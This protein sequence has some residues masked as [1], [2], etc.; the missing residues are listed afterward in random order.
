MSG[1]YNWSVVFTISG[2]D[3]DG[4]FSVSH[5]SLSAATQEAQRGSRKQICAMKVATCSNGA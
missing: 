4:P 5:S 2:V 1:S 3:L